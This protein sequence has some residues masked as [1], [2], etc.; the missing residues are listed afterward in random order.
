[1]SNSLDIMELEKKYALDE[2]TSQSEDS[3]SVQEIKSL[4][5][6]KEKI[7]IIPQLTRISRARKKL[8]TVKN[9]RNF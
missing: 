4:K 6:R 1:M 9:T 5:V 2:N 8:S 3:E 7:T